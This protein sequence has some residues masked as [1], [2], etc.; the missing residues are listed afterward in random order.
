MI[1]GVKMNSLKR[2]LNTEIS[3]NFLFFREIRNGK[4]QSTFPMNFIEIGIKIACRVEISDLMMIFEIRYI[5]KLV[6]KFK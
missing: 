3:Y 1:C 2:H 4:I 6:D 5:L